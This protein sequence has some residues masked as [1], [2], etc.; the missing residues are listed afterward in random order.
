MLDW[1][2]KACSH[3]RLVVPLVGRHRV[4]RPTNRKCK[5]RETDYRD[6]FVA[7]ILLPEFQAGSIRPLVWR[8]FE[9]G[10]PVVT[11]NQNSQIRYCFWD[12]I[13]ITYTYDWKT[14]KARIEFYETTLGTTIILIRKLWSS[15]RTAAAALSLLISK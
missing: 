6:Q 2:V 1:T 8:Q 3:E 12:P 5:P 14:S 10:E 11:F 15:L 13:Q 9:S 7:T 4:A